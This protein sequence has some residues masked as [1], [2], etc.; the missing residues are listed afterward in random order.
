M[1]SLII[2]AILLAVSHAA[3]EAVLSNEVE[4]SPLEPQSDSGNWFTRAFQ[5]IEDSFKGLIDRIEKGFVKGVEEQ[6]SEDG[7]FANKTREVFEING[8]K[9]LRIRYV[10]SKVT[11]HS[12]VSELLSANNL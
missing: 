12:T 3:D 9:F 5:S 7:S 2:I 11:N 8:V 6:K 1:K 4:T 10:Q